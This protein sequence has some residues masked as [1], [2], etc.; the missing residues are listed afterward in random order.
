MKRGGNSQTGEGNNGTVI[1]VINKWSYLQSSMLIVAIIML[2]IKR[3][4][5]S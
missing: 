4:C 3:E 1:M 2:I 5:L